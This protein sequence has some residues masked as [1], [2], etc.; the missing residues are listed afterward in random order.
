MVTWVLILSA[1]IGAVCGIWLHVVVFTIISVIVAVVF[2]FSAV[3][4]GLSLASGAMWIILLSTALSAGYITSHVLRYVIHTRA[5]KAKRRH[6]ELDAG[7]KYI[8][9]QQQQ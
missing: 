3:T 2:L 5:Q 6:S 1:A 4:S 9:D 7:T 8:H